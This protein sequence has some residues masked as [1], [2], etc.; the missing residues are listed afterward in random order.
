M[1]QSPEEVAL[2]GVVDYIWE[3]YDADGSG[4]LD[5]KETRQLVIDLLPDG[6]QDFSEEGYK[7]IY[8]NF[9]EKFDEDGNGM[10]F[11]QNE[12]ESF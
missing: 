8:D 1:A 4:E 3:Q 7:Q 12:F 6:E 9:L 5:Y 11:S 2:K 10:V